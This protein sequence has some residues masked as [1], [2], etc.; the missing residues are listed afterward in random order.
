[1]KKEYLDFLYE[2]RAEAQ[3]EIDRLVKHRQEPFD[4]KTGPIAI[5]GLDASITATR[6]K[7]QV[8][9]QSIEKYIEIHK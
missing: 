6:N 7:I 3:A 5:A 2:R 9:N 1:M 4:S 8:I